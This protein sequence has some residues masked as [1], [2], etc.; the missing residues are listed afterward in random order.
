MAARFE[1]YLDGI[2]IAN[3]FHEL[4]DPDEQRDRFARDLAIRRERGQFEPPADERLL[5][6]MAAGLPDCAG[7]ALGFDRLVAVGLGATALAAAMAF[8]VDNA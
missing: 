8:P 5:A 4:A 7:V 1:L 3:G 2:E 6:A